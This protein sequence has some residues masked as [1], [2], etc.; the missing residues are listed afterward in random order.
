[1]RFLIKKKKNIYII[2]LRGTK[3]LIVENKKKK[4]EFLFISLSN[5]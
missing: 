1:M 2:N 4:S 3:N 5:E